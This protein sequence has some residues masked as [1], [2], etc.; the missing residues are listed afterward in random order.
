VSGAPAIADWPRELVL[1]DGTPATYEGTSLTGRHRVR[2]LRTASPTIRERSGLARQLPPD[3][4]WSVVYLLGN[5]G[6]CR[7]D[8]QQGP[9][10]YTP[11]GA[12]G[13]A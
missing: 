1:R 2:F 10:D 11:A 8:G 9:F 7:C 3:A 4:D 5:D 13:A 12:S 6:V